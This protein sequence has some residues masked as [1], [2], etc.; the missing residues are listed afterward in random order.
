[1]KKERLYNFILILGLLAGIALLL[2]PTVSDRWNSM[3]QTRAI[4]NYVSTVNRMDHDASE[5]LRQAARE[6]NA[7]RLQSDQYFWLTNTEKET[8]MS[9]MNPNGDSIMGY[10][11]I[12][13]LNLSL[14]I[15]HG[16]STAVL[17]LGIGHM[18]FSALP[19]GGIGSHTV[20]SGHRG[21]PTAKLFTDL[22][23]L[24]EGDIFRLRI[25]D[26]SLCYQIDQILIV[27]PEE[28][29]ALEPI[30]GK[31]L[32]TLVTCTPYGLNTHRMLV[33]GTRVDEEKMSIAQ[34][35][36]DAVQIEKR[37]V[38]PILMMLILLITIGI[39][40]TGD[41]IRNKR[42]KNSIRFESEELGG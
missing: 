23:K 34:V 26:E 42:K 1:M 41:S 12:P 24:N 8:Y 33:R 19:V 4:T 5:G 27:E 37:I 7:K 15:Y 35:S 39:M 29:D 25:L 16:T 38:T 3:H 31:D 22:D 36:T 28:T 30:A 14:P 17:E 9:L 40:L 32:C 6:F 2:Y 13:L 18:E 20:L 10:V 11:E 21:L